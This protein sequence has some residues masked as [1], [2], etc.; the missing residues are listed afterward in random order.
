MQQICNK[1]TKDRYQNLSGVGRM[2]NVY[3]K[4]IQRVVMIDKEKE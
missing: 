4:W 1:D 2:T 3:R